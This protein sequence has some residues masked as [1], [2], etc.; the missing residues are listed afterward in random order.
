[1]QLLYCEGQA[2]YLEGKGPC[3]SGCLRMRFI[4]TTFIHLPSKFSL[5]CAPMACWIG[6]GGTY[7]ERKEL[8]VAGVWLRRRD[9]EGTRQVE[10][11]NPGKGSRNDMS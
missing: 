8:P 7:A 6:L 4:R 1:M 2:R 10:T 9:R 3:R 11:C 5:T